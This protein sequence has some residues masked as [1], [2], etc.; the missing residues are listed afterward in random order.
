LGWFW[1]VGD[2]SQQAESAL[3]GF[4]ATAEDGG[5]EDERNDGRAR[6]LNHGDDGPERAVD[7]GQTRIG[8]QRGWQ[9]QPS[10]SGLRCVSRLG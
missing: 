1:P 7:I 10:G 3:A 5:E 4:S 9:D 6:D 8:A 2:P